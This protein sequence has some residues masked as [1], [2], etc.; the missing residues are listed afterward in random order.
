MNK[1]NAPVLVW[2]AA[3][4]LLL[5]G[6]G[7][8]AGFGALGTD[9][10]RRALLAIQPL[11]FAAIVLCLAR[12]PGPHARAILLCVGFAA[13]AEVGWMFLRVGE[14]TSSIGLLAS[15]GLTLLAAWRFRV[16]PGLR[17]GR[18]RPITATP[19]GAPP[20]DTRESRETWREIDNRKH[21]KGGSYR[22]QPASA[23]DV[24]DNM[25]NCHGTTF[26]RGTHHL[27]DD[28]LDAILADGYIGVLAADVCDVILWGD[29]APFRHSAT[30]V[31]VDDNG[32]PVWCIG[33]NGDHGELWAHGPDVYGTDWHVFRKTAALDPG[34]AAAVAGLKA[35]HEAARAAWKALPDG[36]A[37]E[38]ARRRMHL[39]AYEL[40]RMKNAVSGLR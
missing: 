26:T 3:L 17:T 6:I 20:D 22:P 11:A 5:T 29:S 23:P 25:A 19:V 21:L 30:V 18:G 40:C 13:L 4:G 9:P 35:A 12:W 7:H 39:A 36:P 1:S 14:L 16:L 8:A 24:N 2:L 27:G 34:Q 28:Q 10:V 15:A 31:E 32:R 38:A 37:K 33:K